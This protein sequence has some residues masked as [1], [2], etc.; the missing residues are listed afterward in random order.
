MA[1]YGLPLTVASLI[2]LAFGC[3]SSSS[4]RAGEGESCGGSLGVNCSDD[5]YCQY[6]STT[7][8]VADETGICAKRPQ[9]CTMDYHPVCG[10]DRHTYPN[11]CAAAAAGQSIADSGPCAVPT[12]RR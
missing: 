7:C 5:L 12:N 6:Q 8:G 4:D 11:A 9:I 10:C 1:R 3:G 2:I